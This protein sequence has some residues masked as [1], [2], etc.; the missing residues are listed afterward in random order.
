MNAPKWN[1]ELETSIEV[2]N[3]QDAWFNKQV[4]KILTKSAKKKARRKAAK[5]RR[6]TQPKKIKNKNENREHLNPKSRWGSNHIDNIKMSD[7]D[8]HKWKH[9]YLWVQLFHEQILT[10]LEDNFQILYKETRNMVKEEIEQILEYYLTW[11]ELYSE[12]CFVDTSKIP[13]KI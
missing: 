5:E 8:K 6:L 3:L 13:R 12:K 2:L 1:I 9:L 11:W 10:I 4:Q 7:I